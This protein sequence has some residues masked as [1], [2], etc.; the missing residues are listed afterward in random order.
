MKVVTAEEMREIDRSTI[1]GYGIPG[2]VLMERAGLAVAS[3]V[4]A[5]SL[6]NKVLVLCGGGNNGGDGLVVARNLFNWGFNVKVLMT[7]KR[8]SLSPDCRQQFQIAKEIGLPIEYRTKLTRA[9]IH[10]AVVVDAVFG[11]GLSRPVRGEVAGIFAFLNNSAATVIAVDIPSGIS[12]DTGDVLGE[13]LMADYTV[14]FGLPKRG[15]LL[16]PGAAYTGR[17][18]VEDIGF[19]SKLLTADALKVSLV[20]REMI[21]PLLP[22]RQRDAHKGDFGHILVIAGARGKT[23]AALMTAKACLRSGA[24]LVTLAVPE[25]LAD[26]IQGR[27][28]EEM[29]LPLPDDGSGMFSSRA[30][31]DIFP[32]I[33]KRADIIAI[34]PG[35]GVSEETTAIM[36]ELVQRSTVPMVIDADGL[37]SLSASFKSEHEVQDAFRRAKSPLVLTPHHGEMAR[38]VHCSLSTDRIATAL[39]FAQS[40]GTCLV[41]KGG[42]TITASPEGDAF[43]N[44]TG[45]PGMATGG[46]GDVLTGI[47]AALLGQSLNPVNAAVYGVYLHGLAGDKAAEV[48]GEQ[49]LIASDIIDALPGA[50]REIING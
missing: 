45:N 46:S 1:E 44:P 29:V 3:R 10:S 25:S 34:G 23:G 39:S 22:P 27:V 43:I 16:G 48:K 6:P 47:I 30:L 32:F 28:T 11:T 49:A 40:T 36:T 41:L 19:P 12:S 5:L 15:H 31:D 17:L 38:L 13:A 18:F 21:A 7:A 8:D 4:R 20:S 9:D 50:F 26:V 14:T 24:G 37:N 33:E 2:S 42:P 35:I